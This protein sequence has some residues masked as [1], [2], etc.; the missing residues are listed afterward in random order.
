LKQIA[1]ARCLYVIGTT[2]DRFLVPV[3]GTPF[4]TALKGK[5][6]VLYVQTYYFPRRPHTYVMP[7][8]AKFSKGR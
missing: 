1:L 2:N 6:G 5:K 7:V 8:R 4:H 3:I